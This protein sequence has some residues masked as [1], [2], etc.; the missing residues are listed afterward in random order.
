MLAVTAFGTLM[1]LVTVSLDT[2]AEDLGTGRATITWTITGLMLTMALLTPLAGTLGDIHGHRKMLLGGLLGGAVAT[3][4]C[5]LAWDAPSLIAFRVLFGVFGA[6]VNPNAMSLMMHAY[7]PERRSTAVGWF[8]F[9]TTGAPTLGLIVGGPLID[10]AG[11]RSVFFLFGAVSAIACVVGFLTVRAIPRAE[12]RPLD[13]AGAFTLGFGVLS[14]LIAITSF[15]TATQAGGV[16]GALTD[17]ATLISIALGIAFLAW[18]VRIERRVEVPMLK[19]DYFR[20]RN[21]S[22]PLMS[23][24]AIQ[25]AYMGGFVITPSLLQNR[26]GWSIGASALLMMPRPGIFSLA[27]PL[28]GWLPSRVGYRWPVV[29]G[30]VS[31]IISM[32]IFAFAALRTDGIGIAMI[33]IALCLTG[34]AAGISQPAI[35][36]L[37]VDSVDEQDMGVANGMNQQTMFVGIVAGIQIMSVV[38]GDVIEPNRYAMTFLI[39]L[40]AAFV[41]LAAALAIQS[42]RP[43][44]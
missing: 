33:V 21:F 18:F 6:A 27:S 44:R 26:Y 3:I 39:G 40:G 17:P 20:R 30:A 10:W 35:G 11:W 8:T 42:L 22:L 32:C 25:F 2:M 31:M 19:L 29:A 13:L 15:A 4:L 37:T 5:G 1:T 24:A 28:G 43:R 9:A 34:L 16:G 23:G 7:G 38:L 12:G 14:I 41:G 36:A